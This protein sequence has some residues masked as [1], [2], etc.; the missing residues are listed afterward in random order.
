MN[1]M[2]QLSVIIVTYNNENEIIP[3]LASLP[4]SAISMEIIVVDSHSAD[5]TREMIN[6]FHES[7]P[8]IPL[9]TFWRSYNEG[10]A[11][12]INL[13]LRH[14]RGQYIL[15][16]GPDT[17]LQPGSIESMVE[18]FKKGNRTGMVAPQLI[19]A[20]AEVLPSCRR[21]PVYKDIFLELTGLPRLFPGRIQPAWKMADFSHME[22]KEVDQP[23][24]SCILVSREAFNEVGPMDE[25]FTIF[26]NDVDWCRRFKQKNWNIWFFPKVKIIHKKGASIRSARIPMIWKSYQ[27]LYRYFRKYHSSTVPEHFKSLLLIPCLVWTAALRSA[28]IFLFS[29]NR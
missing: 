16:L 17:I 3:C 18:L 24:A 15:I 5:R 9:F 10:Y 22:I 21:F 2:P 19:S 29:N 8:E 1:K 4:W 13:G 11:K 7:R 14:C 25:R 26:F 28:F 6:R 12:G 23:E 20:N 27:G